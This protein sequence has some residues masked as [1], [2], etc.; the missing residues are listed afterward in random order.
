VSTA[1]TRTAV[2]GA[3][4]AGLTAAIALVRSGLHCE[5][6]EQTR[7]LREVGAGI[8]IAPNA[9][10]FLHRLGLAHYLQAVAVRPEAIEMRRWDDDRLL[11]RTAL[12][13]ECEELFG[14]PYYTVHRADLHRGLLEL[15]PVGAVHL[16]MRCTGMK[17]RADAVELRFED[18][19]R[20][21]ADTVV[22]ADG[23][24]SVIREMLIADN[25]RFSGQS[26]YR[27]LVPA[28]RLPF[29]LDEPKVTLWL[30][31]DQHCVSYPISGGKL[32]SF[33][34][35]VTA[36]DWCIESWSAV[37]RVEELMTSY[38]QWNPKVRRLLSASDTVSR[39]ALYDRDTIDRW[40]SEK[41]TLVGDAA[42]PMLPFMAQGANQAI[43]DAVA[44]AACLASPALQV[45][46]ALQRY[47]QIRKHRTNK[48]HRISRQNTSMFH[49]PD[50]EQQ[51]HR[52]HGFAVDSH[53]HSQEW[54][55]GYDAELAVMDDQSALRDTTY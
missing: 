16:G 22:G 2:V 28:E 19:S 17:E 21:I 13:R 24:H 27:G 55:Y 42:H 41:V 44:L 29:L 15:L 26:I 1:V 32:I 37:G 50:G 39:W 51:Q 14:A 7:V 48:V 47:E 46:A 36:E 35:T 6:F 52:D 18:G 40:S 25:P 5:V 43:E 11:R 10:K 4:I 3:G 30:G 33:G 9:A 20:V 34:A 54:L 12:G 31:P 49:L 53:L 38:S 23:I 45:P 8:Q